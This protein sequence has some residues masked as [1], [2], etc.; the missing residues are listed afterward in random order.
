MKQDNVTEFTALCVTYSYLPLYFN[1]SKGDHQSSNKKI[2]APTVME[3]GN[4]TQAK[5]LLYKAQSPT[6]LYGGQKFATCRKKKI[7]RNKSIRYMESTSTTGPVEVRYSGKEWQE[8]YCQ[9]FIHFLHQDTL[10][11]LVPWRIHINLSNNMLWYVKGILLTVNVVA[12]TLASSPPPPPILSASTQ[13]EEHRARVMISIV[14]ELPETTEQFLT[15]HF[16]VF[17]SFSIFLI[18]I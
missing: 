10:T 18:I 17:F 11:M 1:F 9:S 16:L 12:L 13:M 6:C 5:K 4:E 2:G 15:D 3:T 14:L 7:A 8:K